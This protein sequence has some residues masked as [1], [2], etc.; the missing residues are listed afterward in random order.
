MPEKQNK[1]KRLGHFVLTQ[2]VDAD[3]S[4]TENFLV[5]EEPGMLLLNVVF[6]R[7]RL[8]FSASPLQM[9]SVQA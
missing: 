7:S 9:F 2:A 1:K 8:P 6:H 3:A 5:S 4:M